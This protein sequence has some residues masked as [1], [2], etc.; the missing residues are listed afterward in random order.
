VRHIEKAES[1]QDSVRFFAGKCRQVANDRQAV[2][3]KPESKKN[4]C[5]R[6]R[7]GSLDF[8]TYRR[9]E[10]RCGLPQGLSAAMPSAG[11]HARLQREALNLSE[12]VM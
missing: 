6:G 2:C 3:T 1:A 10:N 9:L 7:S 5:R 11:A 8:W 12:W 4:Q